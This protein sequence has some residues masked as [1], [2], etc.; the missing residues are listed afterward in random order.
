MARLS[1]KEVID[2]G[3][4]SMLGAAA[5]KG[6]RAVGAVGSALSKGAD[7]GIDA[8]WGG[9][10]RAGAE[11]WEKTGEAL[12]GRVKKLEKFLDDQ[13]LMK[14]N[15][16][17]AG[18]VPIQ[19]PVTKQ[20]MRGKVAIVPIVQYDYTKDE[21]TGKISGKKP[22]EGVKVETRKYKWKDKRW[23]MLRDKPR[24]DHAWGVTL[25]DEDISEA[26]KDPDHPLAGKLIKHQTN[27]GDIAYG[28]VI[29]VVDEYVAIQPHSSN[30][31]PGI[32]G[33]DINAIE[34]STEEE[35]SQ[36]APKTQHVEGTNQKTLLRQLH[37]LQG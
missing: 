21:K 26:K 18:E 35:A 34:E 8:T 31:A 2:E 1:Q 6:A 19:E 7:M 11:G 15:K 24:K 9:V 23:E 29:G 32:Y 10:A 30:K 12:T 20:D 28:T 17:K 25:D 5:K 13:G 16:P 27:K 36:S 3:I 37:L 14:V 33:K 4:A 22:M